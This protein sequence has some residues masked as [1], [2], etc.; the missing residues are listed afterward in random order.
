MEEIFDRASLARKY[1]AFAEHFIQGNILILKNGG[2]RIIRFTNMRALRPGLSFVR[3][4]LN[5]FYPEHNTY[6][7]AELEACLSGNAEIVIYAN[8][9]V[10]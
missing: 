1:P 2:K 10:R 8:P 3:C 4:L 6:N 7:D 9:S 5:D